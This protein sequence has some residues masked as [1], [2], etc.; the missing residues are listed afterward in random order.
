MPGIG[1]FRVETRPAET[2][3]PNRIINPPG[4]VISL[5]QTVTTSSRKFFSSLAYILD[6]SD[7]DAIIR[8][9]DFVFELKQKIMAG[10]IITWPGIGTLSKDLAGQ[11]KL[12]SSINTLFFEQPVKAN[13]IIRQKAEHTV[14]VGEDEKTSVEM[15]EFL[16]HHGSKKMQWWAYSLIIGLLSLIFIFW[17][18]SEHGVMTTSTGNGKKLDPQPPAV[19]HKML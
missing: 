17:H 3:F 1:T 5:Q 13:K 7:R 11:V 14:R 16:S 8:F 18:F 12:D 9:N 15:T 6:I 4:Y 19:T 10:N 2:D